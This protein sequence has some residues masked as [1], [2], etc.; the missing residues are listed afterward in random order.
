MNLP[1]GEIGSPFPPSGLCS[2]GDGHLASTACH[3]AGITAE[4]GG[5]DPHHYTIELARLSLRAIIKIIAGNVSMLPSEFDPLVA[6]WFASRFVCVPQS[7]NSKVGGRL[8]RAGRPI[9]AP[10]GSGKTLAAFLI[11]I[12]QLVRAAR[13]GTLT[14]DTHVVYVISFEGAF[15]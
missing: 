14:D 10:T 3:V 11:C 5:P 2:P 7:R 13:A 9:S 12:D 15:E 8:L 6:E 1:E 4:S